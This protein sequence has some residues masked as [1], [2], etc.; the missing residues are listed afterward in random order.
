[1][2]T[3]LERAM[4][5]TVLKFY[6]YAKTDKKSKTLTHEEF[7]SLLHAELPS[8]LKSP[9]NAPS[10]EQMMSNL[11]TNNDGV[12]CFEEYVSLVAGLV[13][14]CSECYEKHLENPEK[15]CKK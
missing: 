5:T 1:M 7:K 9:K 6:H 4:K 2:P 8:F 14:A 3:D 13:M 10:V 11:D 15:Q 12:F